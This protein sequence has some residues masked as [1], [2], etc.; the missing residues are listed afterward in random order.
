MSN[1][2]WLPY[3]IN[4]YTLE[5]KNTGL[6]D[7]WK[8]TNLRRFAGYL[9]ESKAH[10]IGISDSTDTDVARTKSGDAVACMFS[11]NSSTIVMLPPL[12]TPEE[13]VCKILEILSTE[14]TTEPEWSKRLD[15]PGDSEIKQKIDALRSEIAGKTEQAETLEKCLKDRG[16]FKKLLYQNGRELED[17]VM[18]ALT[19]LGLSVERGDKD[20]EDIAFTLFAGTSCTLCPIEIKGRK[21]KIKK[22]SMRQLGD[23]VKRCRKESTK[24][25]GIL[26]VNMHRL[27][28]IA[29]SREERGKLAPDQLEYAQNE[30]FCVVPTYVLFEL[31]KK[32]VGGQPIDRRKIEEVLVS[33]V[34][35]VT[36]EDLQA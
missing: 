13:S 17:A 16:S 36:L 4:T 33:T 26:V 27:S 14:P 8:T 20:R 34:G 25:K 24:V 32:F 10:E 30:K 35:I 28:D 21:N 2:F 1:Y 18:N 15:V 23:W 3:D 12:Q 11:S 5:Y 7:R 6:D 31:C 22:D 29:T 19:M 9:S